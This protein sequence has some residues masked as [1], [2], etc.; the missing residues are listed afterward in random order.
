MNRKQQIEAR[1]LEIRG[2]LAGDGHCDVAALEAEVRTLQAEKTELEGK[3][4]RQKIADELNA[5]NIESRQVEKPGEKTPEAT[6]VDESEKRGKALKENRSVT[7][8]SSN[9]VLPAHQATDI[10]PTFNEV[11]SLIDRVTVKP[12]IGGESFDQPYLVGFGEGDYTTEGSAYDESEPAFDKAAIGKAKITCYAEE[13]EETMKLPAADYDSVIV[14]GITIGARK[15]ITK[16]ILVGTGATNH[17]AGI[18]SAAAAAIDVATDIELSEIDETTL[19]EIIYSYG[20][21]EDVEDMAVLILNK[22][23]LKQFATLRDADG[24][25]IYTIVNRGNVGTID[26]VP[27][28]INSACK[29]VSAAG[30]TSGQYCMA[31]GPLSNYTMAVFSQLEV[32]RSTDFKF[33]TGM[34]AH[35]GVIFAGGNV[36][37]K[38]GFLRVKKA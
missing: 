23:D 38:N 29:A 36:T 8:A 10:K 26:G 21:D 9:I 13:S 5:E 18:F 14:S 37:A 7:V 24:E 11:S 4:K 32:A 20:G 1:L 28:I 33:S 15:K 35:K 17:F 12:L 31:Y 22:N 34:I 2:I 30:T 25:K 19:D 27:F 16:E 6:K 3:E